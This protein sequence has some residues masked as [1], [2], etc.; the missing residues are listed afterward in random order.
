ML[1]VRCS[2]FS[3]PTPYLSPTLYALR[4]HVSP[5]ICVYEQVYEYGPGLFPYSYTYSYTQIDKDQDKDR[6][7]DFPSETNP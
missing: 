3:G 4:P 6:D 2:T 1:N 7:K 5:E